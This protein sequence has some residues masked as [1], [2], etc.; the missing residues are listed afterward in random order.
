VSLRWSI[1]GEGTGRRDVHGTWCALAAVQCPTRA[2]F[3]NKKPVQACKA[4]TANDLFR[5]TNRWLTMAR[6][7]SFAAALY[8][9]QQNRTWPNHGKRCSSAVADQRQRST[10]TAAGAKACEVRCARTE[11]GPYWAGRWDGGNCTKHRR[12]DNRTWRYARQT[13]LHQAQAA[14]CDTNAKSQAAPVGRLIPP[15]AVAHPYSIT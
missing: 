6:P 15:T 11:R 2:V 4:P 1:R 3:R 8:R 5:E 10:A 7:R 14:G 9:Q 13:A 12:E